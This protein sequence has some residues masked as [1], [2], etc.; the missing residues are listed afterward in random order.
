MRNLPAEVHR[1]LKLR[2]ARQGRSME[3]E[4]RAI[5]TEAVK[6]ERRS[7]FGSVLADIGREAKL[8]DEEFAVFGQRERTRI[9]PVS[10][11]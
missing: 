6:P 11:Q 1:A 8:T 10:L 2:A 5:L 7:K 9:Q 4:A 3:A